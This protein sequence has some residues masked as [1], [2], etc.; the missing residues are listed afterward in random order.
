MADGLCRNGSCGRGEG[1]ETRRSCE[2]WV[3][4]RGFGGRCTTFSGHIMFDGA[5][6]RP[7]AT[8]G[9]YMVGVDFP[10]GGWQDTV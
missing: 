7:I 9:G 4:R 6:R 1:E 3:K 2:F 10:R 5:N 8:R